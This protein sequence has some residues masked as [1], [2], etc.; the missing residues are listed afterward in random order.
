ME[1]GGGGEGD[2]EGGEGRRDKELARA[3]S[4]SQLRQ[5]IQ[6]LPSTISS[7]QQIANRE[8]DTQNMVTIHSTTITA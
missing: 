3:L 8:L 7:Q 6:A 4:E 5:V 2:K 1:R